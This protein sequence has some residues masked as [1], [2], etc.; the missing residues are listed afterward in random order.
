M[1]PRPNRTKHLG[2]ILLVLLGLGL[3]AF[4]AFNLYWGGGGVKT[5]MGIARINITQAP[6][7]VREAAQQLAASRVGYVIPDGEV[8]YLI[9]STGLGGER[10]DVEGAKRSGTIIDID[11]RTSPTKGESLIIAKLN[12][13]VTDARL[14]QF[15]LDGYAAGIP[16]LVNADNLPLVTLPDKESLVLVT[17]KAGDRVAGGM[18]QVSGYAK[19]FEANVSVAVYSAGKGRVLGQSNVTAAIGAPNWGSF[20][21]NV[22]Y[23]QVAGL[24]EGVILVYDDDSG[25]KLAVPVRFG[26]K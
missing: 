20:R 13:A 14:V 18:V 4:A 7:R 23:E 11:V 12:A 3:A 10:V 25:A 16:A 5:G 17:P 9:I 15:H 2:V 1:V 24:A 21:I 8:S 26:E 19:I 6:L 22:P